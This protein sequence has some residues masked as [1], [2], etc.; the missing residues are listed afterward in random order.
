MSSHFGPF[1]KSVALFVFAGVYFVHTI[2]CHAQGIVDCVI[3]GRVRTP[4]V[5]GVVVDP[6]GIPV[7][8]AL[9]VLEANGERARQSK[10][11]FDGKFNLNASAG[12]YSFKVTHPHFAGIN[13][14]LVVGKGMSNAFS[15]SGLYT[16]LGLPGS[17]CPMIWTNANRFHLMIDANKKSLEEDSGNNATQK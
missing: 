5:Q 14:D 6:T 12:T 3:Q 1:L 16:V 2:D 13:V 4:S 10:T 8:D 9:V 17:L 11:D 7:Q 15:K